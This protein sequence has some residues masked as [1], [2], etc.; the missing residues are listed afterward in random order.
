MTS[1]PLRA[2]VTAAALVTLVSEASGQVF[3]GYDEFCGLPVV[4]GSDPQ[5][6]TARRDPAGRPFIHIDPGAMG[7][8]TMSRRFTLAHECAHHLLGH[9][10]QLGHLHR[11]SGG[12]ARQELEADC[13]A[14][15]QLAALGLDVDLTRTA[16][17]FASQGHFRGSNYP[18]GSERA[19]NIARCAGARRRPRCRTVRVP[20]TYTD[21]V[22]RM[23]RVQ[24]PCQHCGCNPYGQ[25]GCTHPFDWSQQPTRVPVTRQRM[26]ERRVCD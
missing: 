5:T 1:L 8:W 11:Y 14:A 25:C 21:F 13:W 7:N 20:E 10:T 3:A 23:Q 12:T 17:Q 2:V 19:A 24:T 16:L 6:A 15:R 22:V 18:T 9:T 4:V 26:V